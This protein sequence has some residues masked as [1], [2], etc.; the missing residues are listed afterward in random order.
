MRAA[1]RGIADR[2][3]RAGC[4][5]LFRRRICVEF[6]AYRL[7][8]Q[9]MTANEYGDGCVLKGVFT[10][11]YRAEVVASFILKL[12]SA[13]RAFVSLHSAEET[14]LFAVFAAKRT[15]FYVFLNCAIT[16]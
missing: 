6:C 1:V 7:L 3:H 9:T 12:L 13:D 5:V 4:R 16:I 14:V 10:P 11:E 15:T 2:D 8:A